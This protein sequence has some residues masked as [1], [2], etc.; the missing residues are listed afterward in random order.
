M[1]L[2]NL[3]NS[4]KIS[5]MKWIPLHGHISV[6]NNDIGLKFF[7]YMYKYHEN[8]DTKF[9]IILISISRDIME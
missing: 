6:N 3:Y 8:I 2:Y 9:Q 4:N 5:W 7:E 1:E